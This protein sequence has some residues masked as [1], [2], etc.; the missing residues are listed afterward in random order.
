MKFWALYVNRFLGQNA[1]KPI[2]PEPIYVNLSHRRDS[3]VGEGGGGGG[4][5]SGQGWA[6]IQSSKFFKQNRNHQKQ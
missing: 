4:E 5:G 6:L 1:P 3:V 2:S